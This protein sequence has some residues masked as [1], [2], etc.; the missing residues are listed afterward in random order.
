[1]EAEIHELT[2]GYALDA[3]DPAERDA[4]ER[5]LAGC[6]SARQEL[7]SFWEVTSA[8]AVAADGPAPSAELRERIL[9]DARAEKQ[10]VVPLDSR[11]R[12]LARA[13]GGHRDRGGSRD[14]ARAS[15]R[16]SLNNDLDDTRSALTAQESAAAVLADPD[17]TTVALQSGSGRLVVGDD[18]DAVLVLD[19]LAAAPAGKTYQAWVVEGQTPVSAGNV[20]HDR[21][22]G[23]R[24]DPAAGAGR[25]GRR[26]HGRGRRRGQLAD[27]AAARRVRLR[28]DRE[29]GR[30]L[31]AACSTARTTQSRSDS[32]PYTCSGDRPPTRACSGSSASPTSDPARRR[33]SAPPSTG[34][35][36]S[37]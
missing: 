2:A 18:G 1:M 15:T 26:R 36:R 31:R 29:L 14:R 21:R 11:R 9:A 20:R 13:R 17:A 32:T 5:H 3:L 33:S 7:A 4:F 35:T 24:A 12:R 34:A 22:A 28:S 23:D 19:D 6:E 27:A 37:R 16:I 25:R 10:T 30:R 8:L